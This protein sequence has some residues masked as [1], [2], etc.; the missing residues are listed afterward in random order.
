MPL[1]DSDRQIS[2]PAKII[3]ASGAIVTAEKSTA[4][5]SCTCKILNAG[6]QMPPGVAG[7]DRLG[8]QYHA[9][10][11]R[12]RTGEGEAISSSSSE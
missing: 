10:R 6:A 7:A 5:F 2:H 4:A 3:K 12:G 1:T 9:F 11:S 8:A